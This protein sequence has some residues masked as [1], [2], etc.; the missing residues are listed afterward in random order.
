VKI[1]SIKIVKRSELCFVFPSLSTDFMKLHFFIREY[2]II[3]E[4]HSF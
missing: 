2:I 3:N 1:T 4:L